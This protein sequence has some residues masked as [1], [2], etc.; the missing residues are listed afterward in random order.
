MLSRRELL[1]LRVA[2]CLFI[3][4]TMV[5]Y[6]FVSPEASVIFFCGVYRL[7]LDLHLSCTLSPQTK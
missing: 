1:A 5:I 3:V 4:I 6:W 2:S 7:Q